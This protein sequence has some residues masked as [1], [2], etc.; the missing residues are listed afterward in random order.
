PRTPPLSGRGEDPLQGDA[1]VEH[2]ERHHVEVRLTSSDVGNASR[3]QRDQISV[4]RVVELRGCARE[5]IPTG[6]DG[7]AVVRGSLQGVSVRRKFGNR[8]RV[9]LL[10]AALS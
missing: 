5:K 1:E 6:K 4:G 9:G 7:G 10:A 2:Q 3:V 8:E